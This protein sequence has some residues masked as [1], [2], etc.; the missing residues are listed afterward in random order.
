MAI[1]VL[2]ASMLEVG[3]FDM[4]TLR[5]ISMTYT[6]CKAGLAAESSKSVIRH[7]AEDIFSP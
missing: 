3:E 6:I 7:I 5:H 1:D 2:L 4:R